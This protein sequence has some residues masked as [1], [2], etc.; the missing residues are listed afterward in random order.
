MKFIL[1]SQYL[2]ISI[3]YKRKLVWLI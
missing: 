3:D 2:I 1:P